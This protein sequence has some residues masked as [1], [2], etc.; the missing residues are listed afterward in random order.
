[1]GVG[2]CKKEAGE[3][4][5]GQMCI[6]DSVCNDSPS[7]DEKHVYSCET[8]N[9]PSGSGWECVKHAGGLKYV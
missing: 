3:A 4:L 9:Q 8:S 6:S 2:P 7:F 5:L 1:M